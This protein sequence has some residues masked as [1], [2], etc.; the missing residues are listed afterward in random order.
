MF[1]DSD[2]GQNLTSRNS[3]SSVMADVCLWCYNTWQVAEVSNGMSSLTFLY[4][5]YGYGMDDFSRLNYQ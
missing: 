1:M 4:D 5:V 2:H 3:V